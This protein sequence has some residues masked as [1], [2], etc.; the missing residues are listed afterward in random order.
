VVAVVDEAIVKTLLVIVLS[1]CVD[2]VLVMLISN[3]VIVELVLVDM[4][5]YSTEV[6]VVALGITREISKRCTVSR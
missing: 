6:V 1:G 2:P 4:L 3:K 5:N